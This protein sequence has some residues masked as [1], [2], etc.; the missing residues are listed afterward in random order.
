[1]NLVEWKLSIGINHIIRFLNWLQWKGIR[2]LIR[3][4]TP[5]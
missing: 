4:L 2:K 5:R 3:I 1:M